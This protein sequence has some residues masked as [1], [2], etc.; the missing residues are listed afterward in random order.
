MDFKDLLNE[1]SAMGLNETGSAHVICKSIGGVNNFNKWLC[2]DIAS[3]IAQS[4]KLKAS[5][6]DWLIKEW[7]NRGFSI[8]E[9][10]KADILEYLKTCVRGE[11]Q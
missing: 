9:K 8:D 4:E 11:V 2:P 7:E 3:Y 6:L 10:T 1:R 5:P